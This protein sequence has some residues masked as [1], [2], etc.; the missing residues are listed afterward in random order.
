MNLAKGASPEG[1]SKRGRK[2]QDIK[3]VDDVAK[4]FGMDPETR[5]AFGRYVEDTKEGRD[6]SFKELVQKALEFLG[7][8]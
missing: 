3:Q 1:K 5:S 2:K 8:R 6:P 7:R 4:Q